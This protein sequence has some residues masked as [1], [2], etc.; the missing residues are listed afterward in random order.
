MAKKESAELTGPQKAAVVLMTIGRDKSAPILRH[1]KEGEVE[2]IT[3]AIATIGNV[4]AQV[5][6]NA[7]LDFYRLLVAR[8]YISKGG[9]DMARDLL[10]EALGSEKAGEIADR[11]ERVLS[12]GFY[13]LKN[14]NPEV[15]ANFIR[16]EHP[17]TVSLILAQLDANQA[18]SVVS[19]LPEE[20]QVDVAMRVAKI[21]TVSPEMIHSIEEALQSQLVALSSREES[22]TDGPR[23][24]AEMLNFV[25]RSIQRNILSGLEAENAEVA[26]QVRDL[27]FVF[28]DL[29]LL[30][31]KSLRLVLQSVDNKELAKALKSASDEVKEKI[32]G[33][34]SERVQ[35]VLQEE[36]EYTGPMRLSDIEA[37]QQT[38]VD[39][40][41]RL[42]DEGQIVVSRGA[43]EEVIV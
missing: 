30:D 19:E 23:T 17:Q 7:M 25:D 29:V 38:I 42:E 8:D 27:M 4:S 20:L 1:L 37:A 35:T 40:I 3:R 41:R 13:L 31:D 12:K 5:Q 18:A 39:Q 14:I 15:L 36:I 33:N 11:V 22:T 21:K 16:N 28:E 24:V 10:T 2:Q 43:K 32:F 34:L 9:I 6:D 26:A